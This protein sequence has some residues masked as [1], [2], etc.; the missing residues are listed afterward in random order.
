MELNKDFWNT[1]YL[2]NE[3]GWDLG[4]ISTPI[5]EY[6]DQLTDKNID[7]I[8]PGGGN[9]YEAEYLFNNGFK[10]TVVIDIAPQPLENIKKRVKLF[11]DS[12]L[13]NQDF[14]LADL[15]ADLI[16]E[17]TFF[18]AIDPSLRKDYAKKI[19]EIIR[20]G[21][22]LIG[23]LFDDKLNDDKPPFGGCKEEYLEYFEPY[24]KIV[25]LERCYNSIEPRNGRELW[26]Q[27]IK[28]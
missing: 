3:I 5:K 25:K 28:A 7:I 11:P 9:S 2:S 13:I 10:N 14:F 18:C 21:G 15:E 23:V 22:K 24:F 17:Q 4:T 1:R 16:I 20:P 19:S 6:V 12:N 8:I 27:L 26:I